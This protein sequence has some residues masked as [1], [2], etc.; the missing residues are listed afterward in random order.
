MAHE[1]AHVAARHGTRQ[2]SR[3]QVVNLA[4]LPLLAA[5]PQYVLSTSEFEEV[6]QNL[7]VMANARRQLPKSW[8]RV[9]GGRP[10]AP[11]PDAITRTANLI[12]MNG[13]L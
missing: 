5:Q 13:P 7:I 10:E 9:C 12:R 2:A 6:K 1:I 3:G 4:S 11:R 8:G